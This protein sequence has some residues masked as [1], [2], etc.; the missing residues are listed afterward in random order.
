MA[1]SLLLLQQMAEGE[2]FDLLLSILR[3]KV[4]LKR[5]QNREQSLGIINSQSIK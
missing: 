5:N 3:E 4:R 2:D 1:V